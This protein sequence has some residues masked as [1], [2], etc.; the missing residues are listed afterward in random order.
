MSNKIKQANFIAAFVEHGRVG[1]ACRV[2]NISR[3]TLFEWKKKDKE[4]CEKLQEA[5]EL[6][7]EIRLSLAEDAI[8]QEIENEYLE[9]KQSGEGNMRSSDY[10]NF[11]KT[12]IQLTKRGKELLG[13]TPAPPDTQAPD[14]VAITK[15]LQSQAEKAIFETP[16]PYTDDG[17][18]NDTNQNSD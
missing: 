13:I 7:E 3:S 2:A 10:L 5:T 1:D 6:V 8:Y 12:Q 15:I 4:F 17:T 11:L 16:P 14:V 9:R 18:E